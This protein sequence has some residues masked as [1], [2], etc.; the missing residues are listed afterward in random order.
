MSGESQTTM[1]NYAHLRD[2]K[3]ANGEVVRCEWHMKMMGSN[4]RLH[5]YWDKEKNIFVVG[6]IGTHLPI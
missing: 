5:F 6:Y 4:L 1:N 3:R 2:F